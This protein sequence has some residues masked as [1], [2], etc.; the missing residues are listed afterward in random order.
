VHATA[1]S[2][3]RPGT[4][5]ASPRHDQGGGRFHEDWIAVAGFG[6]PLTTLSGGE[7]QRVKLATH[8]GE[9]GGVYILDEPTSGLHLAD[10]DRLLGLLDPH[11]RA[12][13]RLRPPLTKAG[14]P[15]TRVVTA[16]TTFDLR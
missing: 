7:R 2:A 6:Q 8:M 12:P 3:T 1:R 16:A 15:P 5:C 9:N 14:Q 13:R 11:R 4:W 10:V